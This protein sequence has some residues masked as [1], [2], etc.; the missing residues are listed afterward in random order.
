MLQVAP[1]DDYVCIN[2]HDASS[3]CP[4]RGITLQ[5]AILHQDFSSVQYRNAGHLT[6]SFTEDSTIDK[7][8]IVSIVASG[9][10]TLT[11]EKGYS[12]S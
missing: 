6:V 12:F 7:K 2:G 10:I 5:L 3:A 1:L 11:R 9:G 8:R 4:I